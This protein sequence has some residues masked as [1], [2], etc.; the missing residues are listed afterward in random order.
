MKNGSKNLK[1]WEAAALLSLCLCLLAAA[2]AQGKQNEISGNVLRLHVLAVSDAPEEQALKL[3]VRDRVLQT[4][5]PLLEGAADSRE[6]ERILRENLHQVAQA[7]A[8][9]SQGRQVSVS[10]GE[11]SYP[12]REYEGFRL[13]A[14]RYRSL[15]V[16]LGEGEGQN[17]WCVVF[18]PVCLSA[19]GAGE[20]ESGLDEESFSLITEQEGYALRFRLLEL[21]GTVIK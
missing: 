11:E 14:G 16:V 7:A 8:G 12:T 9:A 17:W 10:L 18:P 20:L 4:V 5:S 19:A 15:R 13:P 6:A 3:Q 1:L 2:W 21:W